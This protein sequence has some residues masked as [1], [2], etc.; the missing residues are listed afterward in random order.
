MLCPPG[1]DFYAR[2]LREGRF[3]ADAAPAACLL[4]TGLLYADPDDPA[5]LRP[6]APAVALPRLLADIE[7][8]VALHRGRAA[9]LATAF[10]PFTRAEPV[11][12]TAT[13]TDVTVLK[14]GPRI[15]AAVRLAVADARREILSI[16]P[17]G[18]RPWPPPYDEP[19]RMAEFRARGGRLRT[20]TQPPRDGAAPARPGTASGAGGETRALDALPPGLFVCDRTV[21]FIPAADGGRLAFEVRSPALVS[22]VATAFDI[23]WRLAEPLSR[24]AAPRLSG[25]AVPPVQREIT[26]LLADGLTDREIAARMHMN[27]RTVRVHIARVAHT[28]GSTSRTQL[29]FLISRS[30]IL[31][32]RDPRG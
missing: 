9:R 29:G 2:A 6:T 8:R 10:E 20:L 26:R 31:E 19:W 14:G 23:L 11:P 32:G 17:R 24:E 28:L 7:G 21:A 27:V 16:R 13:A 12:G 15:A 3:P 25:E 5:W 22:Y 30:G 4:A 1:R 18:S